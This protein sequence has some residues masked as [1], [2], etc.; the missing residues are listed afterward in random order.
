M[1]GKDS[2]LLIMV[3]GFPGDSV[4][5]NLPA[6]AGH[7]G[8]R[9]DAWVRKIP[10][11]RK[12]QPTPASLPGKSCGQRSLAGYSAW[13]CN[14]VTKPPPPLVNYSLKKSVLKSRRKMV[15]M[16]FIANSGQCQ[17]FLFW[18][19]RFPSHFSD[20]SSIPKFSTRDPH[21]WN[22]HINNYKVFVGFGDKHS[23][24]LPLQDST[25]SMELVCTRR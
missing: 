3:W 19:F 18:M 14:L 7:T 25:N 8:D 23:Q 16:T 22:I 17:L 24:F 4:V 10:W 1:T 12:W 11:R 2:K 21:S 15:F 6:N 13:G 20:I 5:K 9:L